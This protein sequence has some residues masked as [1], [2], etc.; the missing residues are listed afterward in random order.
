MI[1]RQSNVTSP[2][3][4]LRQL[5]IL[6]SCF[7]TVMSMSFL[8]LDM[9]NPKKC[10]SVQYA[11]AKLDL[12]YEIFDPNKDRLSAGVRLPDTSLNNSKIQIEAFPPDGSRMKRTKDNHLVE[13]IDDL[14]GTVSYAAKGSG[15]IHV[16]VS[17]LELPGRKY[18]RPT[19]LGLRI[20]ENTDVKEKAVQDEKDKVD[21]KKHLSE[22]ER[23]LTDMIRQTNYLLKNADGIKSDEMA[24][25]Q[26]SIEMNSASRWWP[27][28]HVVVLL[29][30][31]FTQANHVIKFFKTMHII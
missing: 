5:V 26:K 8:G 21:T 27:M 20:T 17:I 18:P 15:V 29:V 25:H 28:M 1:F 14:E 10:V 16:C 9:R 19:L 3:S 11:G 4:L 6:S 13:S 24:F 7:M 22:M 12:S 2:Q 23:I 31:G 30:T